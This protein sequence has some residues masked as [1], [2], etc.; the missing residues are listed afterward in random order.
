MARCHSVIQVT[1][2][3]GGGK[4]EQLALSIVHFI[5]PLPAPTAG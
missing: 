2:P 4:S 5:L 3:Y 1:R